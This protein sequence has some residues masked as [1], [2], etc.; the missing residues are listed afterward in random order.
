MKQEPREFHRISGVPAIIVK[1]RYR[2]RSRIK[3]E[4]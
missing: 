4:K 2:L 3:L 1:Q